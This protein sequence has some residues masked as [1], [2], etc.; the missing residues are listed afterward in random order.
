MCSSQDPLRAQT[1]CFFCTSVTN[2]L[3]DIVI[4]GAEKKDNF[5]YFFLFLVSVQPRIS[6]NPGPSYAIDHFLNE[7]KSGYDLRPQ[8][9]LGSFGGTEQTWR[10]AARL[11]R[12]A[13]SRLF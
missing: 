6:L 12:K 5:D 13:L 4:A 7:R 10:I 11:L 1:T 9:F 8:S 2:L 3:K